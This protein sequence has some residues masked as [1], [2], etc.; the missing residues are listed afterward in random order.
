MSRSQHIAVI[1]L[2]LLALC[3]S[4]GCATPSRSIPLARPPAALGGIHVRMHWADTDGA[5]SAPTVVYLTADRARPVSPSRERVV[6]IKQSGGQLSPAFFV[7]AV[8]QSLKFRVVD[9]IHHHIFSKSDVGPFDLGSLGE[10]ESARVSFDKPGILRL[11]CTLHH[12]ENATLYISPSPHFARIPASG[13]VVLDGLLP[14]RYELH[15]WS[16]SRPDS[17]LDIVVYPSGV[18]L[19]EIRGPEPAK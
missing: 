3:T 8:R 17:S 6:K 14:G 2:S 15:T 1:A 4:S 9:D 5:A 13:E 16:E 11:Y 18:S 10:G 12:S 19:A 7:A